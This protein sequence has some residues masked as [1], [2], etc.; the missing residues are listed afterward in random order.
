MRVLVFSGVL[1]KNI[2]EII[3]LKNDDFIIAV[4]QAFDQLLKQKIKIDLVVGDMD[5]VINTKKLDSFEQLKFNSKKDDSDTRLAI[6]HAYILS[7]N[8]ILIGGI[9]GN[10]IEHFIANLYL[11]NEFNNLI[12]LDE[13]SKIYLIKKGKHIIQKGKYINIFPYLKCVL[14]L[15]G[16]EYDLL[17]Y[18]LKEFDPLILSNEIKNLMGEIIIEEGQ[19]IVIETKKGR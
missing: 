17:N 15:K 7:N 18:N 3:D 19:A 16:F 6:K 10:R 11:F 5:S 14:T 2:K 8:V 12:M 1:P 9:K 13:N 4:D